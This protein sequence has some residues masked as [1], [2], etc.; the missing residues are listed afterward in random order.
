MLQIRMCVGCME[1]NSG[2][3][4]KGEGHKVK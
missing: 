4:V 1:L 3:K 2:Q